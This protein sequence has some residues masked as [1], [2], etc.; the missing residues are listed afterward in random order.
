MVSDVPLTEDILGEKQNFVLG[1]YEWLSTK[2]T[3]VLVSTFAINTPVLIYTVPEGFVLFL[4][5]AYLSWAMSAG[6]GVATPAS[7]LYIDDITA[8]RSI[9]RLDALGNIEKSLCSSKAFGIPFAIQGGSKVFLT[10]SDSKVRT[11]GGFTGFLV[12]K[13]ELVFT[14]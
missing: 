1:Y 12:Q 2:G 3:Q 7:V 6:L 14:S 9:L 13:S 4:T 10:G 8:S 11:N 5:N